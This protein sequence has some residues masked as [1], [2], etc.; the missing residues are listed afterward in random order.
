MQQ[1]PLNIHA[2]PGKRGIALRALARL[3]SALLRPLAGLVFAVVYG[4]V[5]FPVAHFYW[6]VPAGWRFA[7][8]AA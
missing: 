3:P 8:G 7:E 2:L 6:Y 5:L 4:W 1:T